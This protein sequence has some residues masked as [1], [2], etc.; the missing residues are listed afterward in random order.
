MKLVDAAQSVSHKTS[1]T[2]PKSGRQVRSEPACVPVTEGAEP[3]VARVQAV[4]LNPE[5][6]IVVVEED[7]LGST[8]GKAD[9]LQRAEGSSPLIRYGK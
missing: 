3:G 5:I 4:R 9:A 1:P 2:G 7:N 8:E 6:G